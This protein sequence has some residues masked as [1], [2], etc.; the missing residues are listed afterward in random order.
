MKNFYTKARKSLAV[1][2][3]LSIL[4]L[5][6]NAVHAYPGSSWEQQYNDGQIQQAIQRMQAAFTDQKGKA[7]YPTYYSGCYLNDK[8]RIT[9]LLNDNSKKNQEAMEELLGISNVLFED[10]KFSRAALQ[11]E[12]EFWS[13]AMVNRD[14]FDEEIKQVISMI[15]EV[16]IYESRNIVVLE[17]IDLDE[18]KKAFLSAFSN[19]P[20]MICIQ[21]GVAATACVSVNPGHQ[22]QVNDGYYSA[23]YRCYYYDDESTT[24]VYGMVT[25]GHGTLI[26]ETCWYG[27]SGGTWIGEIS[28][29]QFSGSVDAS[30]ICLLFSNSGT[31]T[32]EWGNKT[33]TGYCTSSY[34]EGLVLYKEGYASM[35]TSGSI[36]STSCSTSYD[37]QTITNLIKAKYSS[38]SGDSGGV[39]YCMSGSNYTVVG[40]TVANNVWGKSFCCPAYLIN[41]AL[42]LTMY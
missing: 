9:I 23:G 31:L 16:Y 17:V 36:V 8:G 4:I 11:N 34:Y 38:A 19:N 25:A 1:V 20:E 26:N 2:I 40:I 42:G 33:I 21:E 10:A 37:G 41:A 14:S 12:Y 13:D 7:N 35:Q 32:T 27:T 15:S 5:A 3:S 18:E 28:R 24:P 6:L 30:V 22:L 39:V 29:R